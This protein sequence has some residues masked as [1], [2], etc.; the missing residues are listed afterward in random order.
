MFKEE[1]E[2]GE[3]RGRRGKKEKGR[4]K[5]KGERGRKERERKEGGEEGRGGERGMD[6]G[7]AENPEDM[8]V[9]EELKLLGP[10][11]VA[12]GGDRKEDNVPEVVACKEIGCKMVFNIGRGGKVQSSSW[13]VKKFFKPQ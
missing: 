12:N 11:I 9:C 10:H 13:L 6:K 3:E 1:K 4:K 2:G 5:K 8:S 7:H